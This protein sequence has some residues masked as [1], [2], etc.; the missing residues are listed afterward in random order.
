VVS[1][2]LGRMNTQLELAL[3][4]DPVFYDKQEPARR[5]I[6]TGWLP[7]FSALPPGRSAPLRLPSLGFAMRH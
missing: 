3:F 7:S 5:Q 4:E 1:D 6:T 2:I